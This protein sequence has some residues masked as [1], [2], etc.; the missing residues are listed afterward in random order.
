MRDVRDLILIDIKV[1]PGVGIEHIERANRAPV[2]NEFPSVVKQMG[3]VIGHWS[4]L[5]VRVL[6]MPYGGAISRDNCP[7]ARPAMTLVH[8]MNKGR[9]IHR[10]A[11]ISAR[12]FRFIRLP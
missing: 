10:P 12:I 2:G 4:F 11:P 7:F 8:V 9:A 1:Q 5:S 3:R 6:H